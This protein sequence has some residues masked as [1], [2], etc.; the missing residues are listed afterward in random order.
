MSEDC[1]N[2]NIILSFDQ[3]NSLT[4]VEPFK[5]PNKPESHG[6]PSVPANRRHP[7]K[8]ATW[9]EAKSL[10]TEGRW[11]WIFAGRGVDNRGLYREA[12]LMLCDEVKIR[13]LRG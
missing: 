8:G 7:E 5:K 1:E 12:T 9:I 6:N 11:N 4:F 13:R 10:K 3:R 2:R